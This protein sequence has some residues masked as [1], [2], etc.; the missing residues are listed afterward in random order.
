M[1]YVLVHGAWLGG[2]C[3]N[4]LAEELESRGHRVWAPDL[5]CEEVGLTQADYAAVVGR[6]PDAVVVG[7]SLAGLTVALVEARL[8]I[9]LAGLLPVA[10]AYARFL[11]PGFGG[12]VRDEL[13]RSYWPDLETARTRLLPDCD[14]ET[15]EW[16]FARLRRQAPLEAH[17]GAIDATDVAIVCARDIAVDPTSFA[18]LVPRIVELD[19]GHFPMFT[20]PGVLADALEELA[21]VGPAGQS[22]ER[23]RRQV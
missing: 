8:R 19:T 18:G 12:S 20:H 23:P 15:P 4:R 17:D 21:L 10:G 13:G 16:A 22:D 2:W 3:W 7:H 9:Y 1:R 6:Q 5:P 14:A 11:V